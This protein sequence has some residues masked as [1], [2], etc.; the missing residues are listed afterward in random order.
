M[1]KEEKRTETE[2]QMF[3]AGWIGGYLKGFEAGLSE[4]DEGY[5][6]DYDEEDCDCSVCKKGIDR[7]D[8]DFEIEDEED[9][10]E[11]IEGYNQGYKKGYIA[12]LEEE[13]EEYDEDIEELLEE[14]D[15]K[16]EA[17]DL[18]VLQGVDDGYLEGYKSCLKGEACYIW[19]EELDELL[20]AVEELKEFKENCREDCLVEPE[21]DTEFL[22][23]IKELQDRIC[24]L[25]KYS[26]NKGFKQEIY[27][28][29]HL[30]T[31]ITEH[32]VMQPVY[33]YWVDLEDN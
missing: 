21:Y 14:V 20:K 31:V 1:R 18:G 22:A 8:L 9:Y 16:R 15:S 25:H 19:D 5:S 17:Y 11:Y 30:I 6:C 10:D 4:A 27:D 32:Q 12:R 26:D 28:I 2:K 33:Q 23:Y 3:N 13:D 29:F 24:R 7:P